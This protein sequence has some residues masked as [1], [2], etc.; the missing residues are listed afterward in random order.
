MQQVP[1]LASILA[2]S[3]TKQPH[4]RRSSI[5]NFLSGKAP[6]RSEDSPLPARLQHYLRILAHQPALMASSDWIAFLQPH[7]NVH[8]SVMPFDSNTPYADTI[9]EDIVQFKANT[10]THMAGIGVSHDAHSDDLMSPLD[11][12]ASLACQLD[13]PSGMSPPP[14]PRAP[15]PTLFEDD[16]GDDGAVVPRSFKPVYD[17]PSKQHVRQSVDDYQLVRCIGKGCMGKVLFNS[18]CTS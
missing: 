10:D 12:L 13:W 11:A 2:P 7:S 3:P 16:G 15:M 1:T 9:L 14:R 5:F 8:A 4:A 17:A 18:S 6:S